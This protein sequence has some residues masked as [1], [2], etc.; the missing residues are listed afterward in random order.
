MALPQEVEAGPQHSWMGV[1]VGR[2]NSGNAGEAN[3]GRAHSSLRPHEPELWMTP[4][5]KQWVW[6]LIGIWMQWMMAEVGIFMSTN[7]NPLFELGG[8]LEY[9]SSWQST[10]I[11]V[12]LLTYPVQSPFCVSFTGIHW[13]LIAVLWDC[14]RYY[15]IAWMCN[16]VRSL[17]QWPHQNWLF[18]SHTWAEIFAGSDYRSALPFMLVNDMIDVL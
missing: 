4:D 14:K 15:E 16:S 18:Y 12:V 10:L 17:P 3:G 2:E 11:L 7:Y 5:P 13:P 6:T 1:T 8:I 9:E